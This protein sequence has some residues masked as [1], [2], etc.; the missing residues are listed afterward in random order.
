MLYDI[1]VRIASVYIYA[2]VILGGAII[3]LGLLRLFLFMGQQT[4]DA[5]Y[6]LCDTWKDLRR[7]K[8]KRRGSDENDH[9]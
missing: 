1:A 8:T 6:R 3:T 5:F 2:A 4:T 9:Q 7:G